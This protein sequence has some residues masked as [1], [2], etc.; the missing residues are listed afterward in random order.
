M[1]GPMLG[2]SYT[3]LMVS[4]GWGV[5]AMSVFTWFIIV[6]L[7][8]TEHMELIDCRPYGLFNSRL[9]VLRLVIL[10]FIGCAKVLLLGTN[11]LILPSLIF[12]SWRFV[13]RLC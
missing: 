7:D 13:H 11:L 12:L 4:F 9:S 1:V 3:L 6:G 8:G 10:I 5:S 2:S